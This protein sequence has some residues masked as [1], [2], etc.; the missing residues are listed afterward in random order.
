MPSPGWSSGR[1][2]TLPDTR[3]FHVADRGGDG[4][5]TIVA[6]KTISAF[7]QSANLVEAV[8][9]DGRIVAP[10]VESQAAF[11][12]LGEYGIDCPAGTV[13]W[14][15]YSQGPGEDHA[16]HYTA[17]IDLDF[18]VR[19]STRLI[20]EE[21]AVDLD[22]GD[23]V[24]IM[25]VAHGWHAGPEGCELSNVVVGQAVTPQSASERSPGG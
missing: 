22:V 25:G 20:L 15:V 8:R 19:G 21:G 24:A 11:L 9:S 12:D 7:Q 2:K 3:S 10:P 14:T 18:V 16:L 1:V 4:R 17:T 23:C 5:S 13:F 6:T